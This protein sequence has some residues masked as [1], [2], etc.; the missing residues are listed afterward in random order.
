[1]IRHTRVVSVFV[2]LVLGLLCGS[3][4]SD[5]SP[6]TGIT[7][8]FSTQATSGSLLQCTKL[9]ASSVKQTI[10]T[11][12]GTMWI[13]PHVF[14]VPSGALAQPVTINAKTAGGT[15]NAVEFKP[16]GLVFLK[17]AYLVLSYAN[18]S[19]VGSS[20]SKQVAY[21]TDSLAILYYVPSSDN[22]SGQQV[23]G[24]ISHFSNYAIAW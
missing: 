20:T 23:T 5:R 21:T 4:L 19:T 13:G 11:A 17:P 16:V 14:V 6:P 7:A 2:V 12:G 15:G 24:Q 10:G 9:A 18:C 22:G 8:E 1:M 3:C